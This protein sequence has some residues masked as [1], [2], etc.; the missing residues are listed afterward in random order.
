M[1]AVKTPESDEKRVSAE[2]VVTEKTPAAVDEKST[3]TTLLV[4]P[5]KSEADVEDPWSLNSPNFAS[6]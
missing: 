5:E 1:E 6:T 3:K 2:Y 4:L